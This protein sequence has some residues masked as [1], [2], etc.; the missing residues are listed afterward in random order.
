MS[1]FRKYQKDVEKGGVWPIQL[2]DVQAKDPKEVSNNPEQ[3]S[4]ASP[5]Q[6]TERFLIGLLGI[7]PFFSLF[8]TIANGSYQ[9]K[10]KTLKVSK[11]KAIHGIFFKCCIIADLIVRM[12]VV[13]ILLGFAATALYKIFWL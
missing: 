12:I 2:T 10:N 11:F 8:E 3:L 1:D 7:A 13:G 5:T 6:N 4:A 9:G